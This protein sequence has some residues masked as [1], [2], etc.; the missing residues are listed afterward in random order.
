MSRDHVASVRFNNQEH[1]DIANAAHYLGVSVSDFIRRACAVEADIL[2]QQHNIRLQRLRDLTLPQGE[3]LGNV[4][5]T[6]IEVT[7]VG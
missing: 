3:T 1:A 7:Y 4:F 5:M 6:P 2:R